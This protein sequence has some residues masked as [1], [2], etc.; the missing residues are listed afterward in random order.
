MPPVFS[1]AAPRRLVCAQPDG[2][3]T[4]PPGPG[5]RGQAHGRPRAAATIGHLP[6]AD[7][8]RRRPR[9]AAQHTPA[10]AVQSRAQRGAGGGRT[11]HVW[12]Q[13]AARAVCPLRPAGDGQDDDAGGGGAAVR[14]QAQPVGV[15]VQLPRAR[16]GTDQHGGRLH[17]RE[18]VPCAQQDADAAARR[19]LALEGRDAPAR[20]R[21]LELEPRR[22][23]LRDAVDGRAQAAVCRRGDASHGEQAVQ[24]GHRARPL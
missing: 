18:A 8:P 23:C 6:R 24:P 15:A 10:A 17:L 9:A 21:A 1:V 2:H 5:A 19:V 3:A 16:G 22:E 11:Q 20:A 13:R 12:R 14:G 4:L 7:G